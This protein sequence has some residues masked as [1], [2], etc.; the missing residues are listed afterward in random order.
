MV[1]RGTARVPQHLG[2]LSGGR[3]AVHAEAVADLHV[4]RMGQPAERSGVDLASRRPPDRVG[5]GI[6][7]LGAL[8]TSAARSPMGLLDERI[9][10][11]RASASA[12][13]FK[14]WARARRRH[15]FTSRACSP[16]RSI[17]S[18]RSVAVEPLR[19]VCMS[20]TLQPQRFL[21]ND[22][23]ADCSL[24]SFLGTAPVTAGA[25]AARAITRRCTSLVPSPISSTLASR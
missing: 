5:G 20:V 21:C 14:R 8:L 17:S 25:R 16:W 11:R 10:A 1:A 2:E 4:Q 15:W 3:R 22:F 23:F 13:R 24:Q 7:R 12:R 9:G 19:I 6:V 18:W